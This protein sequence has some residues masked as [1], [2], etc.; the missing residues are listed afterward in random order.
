M[1]TAETLRVGKKLEMEKKKRKLFEAE[2][3]RAASPG[4]PGSAAVEGGEP[5]TQ[6]SCRLQVDP[7]PSDLTARTA[8]ERALRLN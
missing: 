1:E 3:P 2:Q 8:G 5:E 4:T 6:D 7:A